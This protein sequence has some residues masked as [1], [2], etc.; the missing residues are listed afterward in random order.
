MKV[1]IT[2]MNGTVAPYIY[3]EL[4]SKNIEVVIWDRS[5]TDIT[6]QESVHQFI[7]EHQ[8]DLFFHIATGP[9]EWV[10]YIVHSTQKLGIKLL[11]T[12]TVSVFSDKGTGPYDISS[13]PNAEDDYGSYKIQC[14]KF[15]EKFHKNAVI[16]RLGWQIEANARPN[17][18]FHSLSKQQASKGFIEAS[19]R[20][21]PSCSFLT[22]TAKT[23]VYCALNFSPG[24]YM[25]N[26]NTKY[27]FFEIVSHLKEKYK[28]DWIV[29]ETTSLERD[30]R[31]IDNRVEIGE[32]F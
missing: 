26:S 10:E 9:L 17:N 31:M 12:S 20:W 21:Y 2:G 11:F 14:E 25:A 22:D 1:I 18:M 3:E 4:I 5:K 13:I 32:L 8:P 6:S 24:I 30:D 19:S 29:K 27:S 16:V 28:T 7:Q 23:V 15:I